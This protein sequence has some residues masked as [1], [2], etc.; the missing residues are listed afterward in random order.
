MMCKS[1]KI[2]RL[3]SRA[4]L[5]LWKSWIMVWTSTGPGKGLEGTKVSATDCPGYYELQQHKSGSDDEC[6]KSLDKR[7]Q[8]K[9]Q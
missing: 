9:L 8:S 6:S 7:K 2:I 4:G 1:E 5:Q 3:K